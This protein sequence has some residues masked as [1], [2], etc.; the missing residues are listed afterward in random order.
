MKNVNLIRELINSNRSR[1]AEYTIQ[2]RSVGSRHLHTRVFEE[3]FC[4]S[5]LLRL[6][7][8][9]SEV[10]ELKPGD[11]QLI[12]AGTFHC[13]SNVSDEPGRFL[14]VQGDGIFDIVKS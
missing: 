14:V 6:T 13:T 9:D 12:P 2:P 10:Y 7:I 5:G 4:L 1:V 3:L 8:A 11:S